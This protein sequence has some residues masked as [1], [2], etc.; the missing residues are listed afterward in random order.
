MIVIT[1][2]DCPPAL[3]GD[4]TKWLQEISTGVY[5]GQVSTRVRDE[6]WERVKD[7][8]K[9]GRATMVFSA[10]NEQRMGFRVHNTGWEPI[11][12]DGLKLM[13]R[14]SPA[15]AQKMGEVRMGFSNA[16]KIRM[17]RQMAGRKRGN[18]PDTY[19]VVDVETTGLSATQH[20][21]IE[22]GSIKVIKG[23]V[24]A[25]FHALVRAR[26]KI[27]SHIQTI[28][29]IFNEILEKEG[30]ELT[31]VLPEFLEFADNL[32]VISHNASFDFGFLRSACERCGLPLFSNKCI[33]TLSLARRL[34]DDVANYK[35]VTLIEYF[36]I[37][38]DGVHRS[39]DDCLATKQL[40]EK[41]IELRQ[42][43]E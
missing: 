15:R 10:H 21:I 31:E 17:A 9:A 19:I 42:T 23:N 4:L 33:D 3:R 41:L 24:A 26:T 25:E 36:G 1:L 39:E 40:Y 22:I 16:A 13:L 20:D 34:V 43:E 37:K 29:G 35:L 27:P 12:F 11:D 32:P 28:T 38:V 8:A 2:T 30:R 7:S 18:K 5:V 6:I 14:P